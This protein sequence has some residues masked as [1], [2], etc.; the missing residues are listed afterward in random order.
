[1][2]PKNASRTPKAGDVRIANGK[3]VPISFLDLSHF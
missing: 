2:W 1:M 3:Q